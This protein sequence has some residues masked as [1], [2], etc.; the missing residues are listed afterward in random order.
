MEVLS[1]EFRTSCPR[2]P[3]YGDDLALIAETHNLL[4]VNM[5][6]TKLAKRF[7]YYKTI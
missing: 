2:E 1:R 5:G 7:G 3:L 4:C 6:K